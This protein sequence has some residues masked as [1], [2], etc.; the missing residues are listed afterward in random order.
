MK[1]HYSLRP[2]ET[3]MTQ[4]LSAS[5]NTIVARF[6]TGRHDSYLYIISLAMV[7]KWLG[8]LFDFFHPKSRRSRNSK[9]IFNIYMIMLIGS[10]DVFLIRK[11]LALL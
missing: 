2:E 10:L 3:W 4:K 1:S 6:K 11:H 5:L 9:F 7:D 8:F